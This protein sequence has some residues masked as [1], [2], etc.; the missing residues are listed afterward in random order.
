MTRVTYSVWDHRDPV[1][2]RCGRLLAQ[3][4]LC[5]MPS[6]RRCITPAGGITS[7]SLSIYVLMGFLV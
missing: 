3:P 4:L 1:S 5:I 7:V 6:Q 2:Q